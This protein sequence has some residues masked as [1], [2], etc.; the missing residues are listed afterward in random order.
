MPTLSAEP[1]ET[2][3]PAGVYVDYMVRVVEK[4]NQ[5]DILDLPYG[6]NQPMIAACSMG[7][8]AMWQQFNDGGHS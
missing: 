6:E 4:M 1:P 5:T 7:V 3:L 2:A 8:C